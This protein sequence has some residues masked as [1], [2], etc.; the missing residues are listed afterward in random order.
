M[1]HRTKNSLASL[2]QA[3]VQ[4]FVLEISDTEETKDI[5]KEDPKVERIEPKNVN[6]KH[7]N[8]TYGNETMPKLITHVAAEEQTKIKH[9]TCDE[10]EQQARNNGDKSN[11]NRN[12]NKPNERSRKHNNK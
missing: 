5:D 3:D 8:E 2:S 9:S 6:D 7:E 10:Q 12:Q 1:S 4:R 11:V